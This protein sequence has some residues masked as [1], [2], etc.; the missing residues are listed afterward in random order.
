MLPYKAYGSRAQLLLTHAPVKINNNALFL[1][2][3]VKMQAE[4]YS[5]LQLI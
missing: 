4:F 5:R 3:N 2:K 1:T